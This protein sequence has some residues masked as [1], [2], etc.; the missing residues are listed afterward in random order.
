MPVTSCAPG[1]RVRHWERHN[2]QWH[3]A[4]GPMPTDSARATATYIRDPASYDDDPRDARVFELDLHGTVA[5]M[6]RASFAAL[7]PRSWVNVRG[8]QVYVTRRISADAIEVY[9]DAEIAYRTVVA[10]W[11]AP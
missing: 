8:R 2:D 4:Y 9:D 11:G 1:D 10:P 7:L 5:D 6:S 3:R